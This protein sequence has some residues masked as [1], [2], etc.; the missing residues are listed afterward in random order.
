MAIGVF[1]GE[2]RNGEWFTQFRTSASGKGPSY[3]PARTKVKE[4]RQELEDG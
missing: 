4:I 2:L 1:L 3:H